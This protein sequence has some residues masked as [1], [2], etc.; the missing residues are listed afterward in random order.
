MSEPRL[1]VLRA[2]FVLAVIPIA[3]AM[4][5]CAHWLGP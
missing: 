3:L 5:S 4:R 1:F 2:A